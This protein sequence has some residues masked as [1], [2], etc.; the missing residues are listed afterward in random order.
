MNRENFEE[1]VEQAS[2]FFQSCKEDVVYSAPDGKFY[3]EKDLYRIETKFGAASLIKI[4][5]H[6]TLSY[7]EETLY[8]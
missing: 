7:I 1:L 6:E 5:R 8:F 3:R 4:Y 2:Y